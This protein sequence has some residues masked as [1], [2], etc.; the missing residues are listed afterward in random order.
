MLLGCTIVLH[1]DIYATTGLSHL[2]AHLLIQGRHHGI[3]CVVLHIIASAWNGNRG[4]LRTTNTQHIDTHTFLLGFLCSL[5][6]PTLVVFTIGDH[7]DSLANTL[8]LG[9][10]ADRHIDGSRNVRTLGSHHRR[11]DTRQ[12]HLGRY[13]VA[14]DRQLH[15]GI[16]RKHDETD[17]VVGEMIHQIL[18][19]HLTTVQTTRYNILC[20]HR[21]GD[22]QGNDGFN[23]CPFLLTDLRTHLRTGQH[24]NQQGEGNQQQPELHPWTEMGYIR[25]QG[26]QQLQ[27]AKLTEPLF[28]ISISHKPNQC[29]YGYQHQQPEIYGVFKS[30]HYGIL[31]KMVMRSRISRRRA[32]TATRAKG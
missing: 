13:I 16:T 25:H 28:L 19:H 18:H 31:L 7:D 11:V 27:V 10:T 6:S 21:I 23:T 29:Q 26:F 22:I 8:F 15:K 9:E 12:E 1:V 3:A 2:T 20:Q 5:Q 17:L 32:S 24:H 4:T 30:K 14:C